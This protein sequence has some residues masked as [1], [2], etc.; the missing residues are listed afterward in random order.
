M[1]AGADTKLHF[2]EGPPLDKVFGNGASE[3]R[4]KMSFRD[5]SFILKTVELIE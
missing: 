1:V 3:N 4:T 2:I 5:T